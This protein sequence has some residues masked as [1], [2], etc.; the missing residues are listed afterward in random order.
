MRATT[1]PVRAPIID[2]SALKA[3]H[4]RGYITVDTRETPGSCETCVPRRAFPCAAWLAA[5]ALEGAQ[6]RIAEL[7][8]R[9]WAAQQRA[10]HHAERTREEE[11]RA[12]AAQAR[13]T[14]AADIFEEDR[15]GPNAA[16]AR[17]MYVALVECT[18]SST[19][20]MTKLPDRRVRLLCTS[21]STE[22]DG[23]P[24]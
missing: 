10:S 23:G 14:A 19:V 13:I 9:A 8:R 16:T 15:T 3:E 5:D 11:Q 22:I 6:T 2:T 7:E 17:A 12:R 24:R 18:H 4:Q 20:E 1:E 21:C